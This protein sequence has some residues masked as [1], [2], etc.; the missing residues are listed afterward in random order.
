MFYYLL[1][2][3]FSIQSL[4]LSQNCTVN[5]D[6]PA[7]QFCNCQG[8]CETGSAQLLQNSTLGYLQVYDQN[9][10]IDY[11]YTCTG[12]KN[13][14]AYIFVQEWEPSIK[15]IHNYFASTRTMVTGCFQWDQNCNEAN[16]SLVL[17]KTNYK[18]PLILQYSS[19][20]YYPNGFCV[21]QPDGQRLYRNES[22][23]SGQ[24]LNF[25]Y[26]DQKPDNT[27]VL[28]LEFSKYQK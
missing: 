11:N 13:N 18:F 22:L 1:L 10:Y 21:L 7:E 23:V 17:V 5:P 25:H 28:I 14:D 16:N 2:L 20:Y 24:Q 6:C 4:V 19:N 9:F 26:P 8:V 27:T 15:A 12:T 3:L